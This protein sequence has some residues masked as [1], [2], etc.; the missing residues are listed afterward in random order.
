MLQLFPQRVP[1]LLLDTFTLMARLIAEPSLP[2]AGLPVKVM[3]VMEAF[4]EVLSRLTI[5]NP[6]ESEFGCIC[7]MGGCPGP[8]RTQGRVSTDGFELVQ[9]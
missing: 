2:A 6:G 3:N 5:A 4:I 8:G 1:T 7:V 9:M